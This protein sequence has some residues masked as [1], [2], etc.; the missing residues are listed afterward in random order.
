MKKILLMIITLFLL[1]LSVSTDRELAFLVE[2]DVGQSKNFSNKFIFINE[3]QIQI[4]KNKM[5]A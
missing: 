2:E 1:K 4:T 5:K 3:T